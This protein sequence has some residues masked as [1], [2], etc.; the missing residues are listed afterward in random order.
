MEQETR[1]LD[2]FLVQ[3][4]EKEGEK[5]KWGQPIGIL[6]PHKDGN[7]FAILC[8]LLYKFGI[9][10]PNMSFVA[11]YRGAGSASEKSEE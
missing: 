7:G 8:D 3:E 6:P 1:P 5:A 4:P 9:I 2:L 11:R 10:P